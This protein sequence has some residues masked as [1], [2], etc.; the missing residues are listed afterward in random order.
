MTSE[1]L[2]MP[3]NELAEIKAFAHGYINALLAH[4]NVYEGFDEFCSYTDN[5]DVNIHTCG[6]RNTIHVVAHPQT[7]GDDGYLNTDMTCW[8]R[9]GDWNM[10]GKQ[11]RNGV[12]SD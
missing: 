1:T 11:K 8:V 5:W 4:D 12:N 7:R 3:D 9:I 6:E 2:T 10:K